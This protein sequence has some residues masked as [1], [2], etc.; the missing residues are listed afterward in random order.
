MA[1]GSLFAVCCKLFVMGRCVLSIVVCC[2]MV[3]VFRSCFL[4]VVWLLLFFFAAGY[5][6]FVVGS[7]S[8]VVC[9]CA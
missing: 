3:V 5:L 8:L 6:L 4:V 7:L 9:S 2:L 1:R